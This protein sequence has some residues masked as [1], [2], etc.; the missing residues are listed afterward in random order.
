MFVGFGRSSIRVYMVKRDF[1]AKNRN[2]MFWDR[3]FCSQAS[4]CKKLRLMQRP[5]Q[6]V[7]SEQCIVHSPEQTAGWATRAWSSKGRRVI[8]F[9]VQGRPL[10]Q[11]PLTIRFILPGGSLHII[12]CCWWLWIKCSSIPCSFMYLHPSVLQMPSRVLPV[13]HFVYLALLPPFS[14]S[15]KQDEPSSWS[16]VHLRLLW[17][18]HYQHVPR[19]IV[20]FFARPHPPLQFELPMLN[21][22][23]PGHTLWWFGKV[24]LQHSAL[25][26]LGGIWEGRVVFLGKFVFSKMRQGKWLIT[27]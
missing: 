20:S 22:W 27:G 3:D 15:P 10:S 11:G 21:A 16:P 25:A 23:Y 12:C 13:G 2:R 24:C 6:Y 19:C 26:L 5:R 4:W 18:L 1:L 9:R 8:V 14:A 7:G 17:F